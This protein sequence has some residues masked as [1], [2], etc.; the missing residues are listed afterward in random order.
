MGELSGV[1]FEMLAQAIDT[2]TLAVNRLAAADEK[3]NTLL[4]ASNAM[5]S[6]LLDLQKAAREADAERLAL[7]HATAEQARAF[8][9]QFATFQ[10]QVQTDIDQRDAVLRKTG[11]I[12]A[13]APV[14]E[15]M[16]VPRGPDGE[17]LESELPAE[18]P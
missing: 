1:H 4:A 11:L 13:P 15:L 16:R 2:H 3:R 18:E 7:A 14:L 8:S 9:A 6:R 10:G 12:G 17:P 5:Q